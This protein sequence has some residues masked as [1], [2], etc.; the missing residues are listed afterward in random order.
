MDKK[1]IPIVM[2]WDEINKLFEEYQTAI[3]ERSMV[4][5]I[6]GMVMGNYHQGIVLIMVLIIT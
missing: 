2:I 5:I 6:I 3:H 4:L 1:N